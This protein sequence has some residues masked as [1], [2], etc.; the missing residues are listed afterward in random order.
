MSA[1]AYGT[2]VVSG[3]AITYQRGTIGCR[4]CAESSTEAPRQWIAAHTGT[5]PDAWVARRLGLPSRRT[6]GKG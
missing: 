4:G 2:V 3:H 5:E 6:G 1:I